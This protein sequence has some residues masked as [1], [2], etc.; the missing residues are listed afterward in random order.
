MWMEYFLLPMN[1]SRLAKFY[2]NRCRDGG[3]SVFG[4]KTRHKTQANGRSLLDRHRATIMFHL[5]TFPILRVELKRRDSDPLILPTRY[6][7]F[8]SSR[9]TFLTYS[10]RGL[11][12]INV[13]IE[14]RRPTTNRPT[15]HF[16]KFRTA[17]SR[18]RVIRSNSCLVLQ[19]KSIREKIMREHYM[20]YTSSVL[21]AEIR[22]S[23]DVAEPDAVADAGKDEVQFSC[24][25]F[26]CWNRLLL[27]WHRRRLARRSVRHGRGLVVDGRRL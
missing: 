2:E 11:H 16:G 14:D 20:L 22:K 23:P 3:E 26:A 7:Y 6:I 9:A 13:Y 17:I 12:D 25:L 1:L 10:A 24:P 27:V 5:Q 19:G 21:V 18:Q 15:S 8:Y 4:K